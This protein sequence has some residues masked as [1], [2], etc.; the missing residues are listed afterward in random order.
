MYSNCSGIK[1]NKLN[2]IEHLPS[3]A[4]VVHTLEPQN[5]SFHVLETFAKCPK[6]KNA[7]AK[8]AKLLF[9][10]VKCANLRR[11]CS[12][13]RRGYLSSPMITP[14]NAAFD[15]L[16]YLAMDENEFKIC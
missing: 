5:R 7:R 1:L 13:R 9:S 8:R 14:E 6:M 16:F 3:Y 12:R 10:I 4:Q 2:K 11:S 15:T